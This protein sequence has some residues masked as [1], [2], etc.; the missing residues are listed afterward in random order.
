MRS[1]PP[2]DPAGQPPEGPYPP[3]YPYPLPYNPPPPRT[4]D[5]GKII[6][7]VVVVVVVLVVATVAISAILY[8]MVSGLIGGPGGPL[9]T[10]FVEQ[11]GTN[12]SVRFVELPPGRTPDGMRLLIRNPEG[13]ITLG[14]TAFSL[15]TPANW[16]TYRAT[17]ADANPGVLEV[18]PPDRLLIDVATYPRGSTIQIS[19]DFGLTIGTSLQ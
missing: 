4:S 19:D 12:W 1:P 16:S 6:L 13:S 5:A 17:Y 18:R 10:V 7:I 8:L 15:L 14:Q 2:L 11:V 9:P 3:P